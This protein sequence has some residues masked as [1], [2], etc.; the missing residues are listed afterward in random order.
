MKKITINTEVVEMMI[1]YWTSVA[2]REKV[3]E[4]YI[5]SVADRPEMKL[6][7]DEEFDEEAVR[8]V[9]SAI[10][11][12]ELLNGG[13]AKEKRFWNNNMWMMEDLGVMNAMVDP[14]KK[15][16]LKEEL[17]S[18]T[19]K[20]GLEE[21]NIIFVPGTTELCKVVKDNLIINFF[22]I[23]VDVFG[24]TGEV[25]LNGKPFKESVMEMIQAV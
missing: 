5:L 9:L 21:L 24:G 2:E 20:S 1:F 3:A 22:K 8:R 18:L 14:M 12:R 6:I 16:N 17:S 13:T 15:L 23:A 10:S 11:N 25:T 4:P 7:Y 19:T